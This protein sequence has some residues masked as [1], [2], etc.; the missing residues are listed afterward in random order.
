METREIRVPE[1]FETETSIK[2]TGRVVRMVF[3]ASK[4]S[5]EEL[6]DRLVYSTAKLGRDSWFSGKGYKDLEKVPDVIEVTLKP[7][8]VREKKEISTPEK[9]T[10]FF[11]K[12]SPE[13]QQTWLEKMGMYRKPT[14]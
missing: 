13:L 10:K 14:V 11:D 12:L 1:R 2:A 6:A 7:C 4:L 5:N 3:D 8:G 9:L